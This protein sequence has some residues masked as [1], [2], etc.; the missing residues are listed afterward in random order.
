M[1][2]PR[3]M[4]KT[5][6]LLWAAVSS[7]CLFTA[8]DETSVVD[9]YANWHERNQRYIDSIAAVAETNADGKWY[10]YK[11]YTQPEDNPNDLGL[12]KDVN[13]YVYCH[14][15]ESGTGTVSPIYTDSIR[16]SYRMWLIND[17]LIDQS[18]RGDFN[19]HLAVPAKFA[20]SGLIT[21]WTTALQYM[22]EGDS[23]T[24]YIPSELGYGTTTSGNIP[25]YSV[26]KYWINLAGVYPTGT[27]L[28]EWK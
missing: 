13:D 4:K 27:V 28:P 8:C 18:F 14:L 2:K 7:T 17:V 3:I 21:G 16:A 9:E 25:G 24:I 20:M 19:P 22:R 12:V 23:W 5:L 6:W 1:Y 15:E 26:L 11:S 10:I